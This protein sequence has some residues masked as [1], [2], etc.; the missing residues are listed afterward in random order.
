MSDKRQKF[1]FLCTA[2][3]PPHHGYTPYYFSVLQKCKKHDVIISSTIFCSWF[4]GEKPWSTK[5]F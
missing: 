3:I 5:K 2:Y 4:N 1:T